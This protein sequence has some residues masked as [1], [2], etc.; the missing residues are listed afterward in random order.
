V[1]EVAAL[2]V[3][4]HEANSRASSAETSLAATQAKEQDLVEKL[5]RKHANQ[6]NLQAQVCS[7]ASQL[8]AAL[9]SSHQVGVCCTT[10]HFA[11]LLYFPVRGMISQHTPQ[12]SAC[13]GCCQILCMGCSTD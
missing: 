5:A 11:C 9:A 2:Q 6:Q 4:V 8:N 7:L 12:S 13:A 10:I 1:Q 3:K